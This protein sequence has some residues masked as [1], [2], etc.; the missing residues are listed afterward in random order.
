MALIVRR[1]TASDV[2][3]IALL[4][5]EAFEEFR[6][7][8]TSG[9]FSATTPSASVLR[10]R[11]KD[12]PIWVAVTDRGAVGTV[13]AIETGDRLYIRSMGVLPAV[14]GQGI[15]AKLLSEVESYAASR[16]IRTLTLSTT[17][18]LDSAIRLYERFGF[19]KTDEGPNDLF[20]TPLFT[21]KKE[22]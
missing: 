17:P 6:P 11:L 16:D 9:G 22:L 20:G 2:E 1:A 5:L 3:A 21:M 12:G 14:R 15:A 13:S 19:V 10:E 18:F 8:Y 4:L 7:L